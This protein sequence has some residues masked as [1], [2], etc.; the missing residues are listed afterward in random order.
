MQTQNQISELDNAVTIVVKKL[1]GDSEIQ[2]YPLNED[3]CE[4]VDVVTLPKGD[5]GIQ[6]SRQM[7][8]KSIQTEHILLDKVCVLFVGITEKNMK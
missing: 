5:V 1:S 2:M 8:N 6:V 3:F 4:F 7:A